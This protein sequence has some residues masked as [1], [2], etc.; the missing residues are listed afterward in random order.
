M[1]AMFEAWNSAQNKAFLIFMSAEALL[2]WPAHT[3][4]GSSKSISVISSSVLTHTKAATMDPADV[5]DKMR[6]TRPARWRAEITPAGCRGISTT[7]RSE[8]SGTMEWTYCMSSEG[9]TRTKER[10]SLCGSTFALADTHSRCV[11]SMWWVNLGR[12]RKAR[13]FRKVTEHVSMLASDLQHT[14]MFYSEGTSTREEEGGS[15]VGVPCLVNESE[16]M[17]RVRWVGRGPG[18][19]LPKSFTYM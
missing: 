12:I 13:P 15:P 18:G 3:W 4:C 10:R 6:G 2:E 14:N 7:M 19:N 1:Q 8:I 11:N 9:E 5:P 17:P 16:P